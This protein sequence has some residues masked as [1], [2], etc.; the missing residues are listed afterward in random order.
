MFKEFRKIVKQRH[1]YARDWKKRTGGKVIGYLCTNVPEPLIYAAGIL[2]V[3]IMGTGESTIDA[4][5]YI[6]PMWC[7]FCRDC[8]A[9]GLRGHYDYLDGIVNANGCQHMRQ[10]YL[11]WT[12]NIPSGYTHEIAMPGVSLHQESAAKHYSWRINQFKN[13]LEQWLEK[14]WISSLALDDAIDVYNTNWGLLSRIYELRKSPQPPL[15]GAEATELVLSSMLMDKREHN[16]MLSKLLTE[17]PDREDPPAQ[18]A[19]I[20]LLGNSVYDIK[21]LEFIESL[22]STIVIDE[23]C[24]G[25]RYFEGK[26]ERRPDQVSA[27]ISRYI[28]R[29]PCPHHDLG[30]P[31]NPKRQRPGYIVQLAKDYNV[32]GAVFVLRKF[33]D[34][35]GFDFPIIRDTLKE[36]GIPVLQLDVGVD[37]PL[38]QLSTRFEAFLE[39]SILPL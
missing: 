10:A 26:I 15:S 25:L 30:Y 36:N 8:F 2:P 28:N 5:K 6:H 16:E 1:E 14:P 31:G 9:Q 35:H 32:D 22:G 18:E 21:F 3:R 19:R 12:K 23:N 4:E 37:M 13:S 24:T 39:T 33:C 27:I 17:L 34:C 7:S 38:G 29:L 11:S 20:M